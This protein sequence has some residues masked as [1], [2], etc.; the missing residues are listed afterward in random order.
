MGDLALE[1]YKVDRIIQKD[2]YDLKML[3]DPFKFNIL[4]QSED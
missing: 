2:Y 3:P 1:D 4:P